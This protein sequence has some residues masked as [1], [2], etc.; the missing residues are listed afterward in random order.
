MFKLNDSF[1]RPLWI[2]VV[3][4][5]LLALWTFFEVV[6]GAIGWA[7]IWGALCVY[8]AYSFFINFNPEEDEKDK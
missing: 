6:T 2:R 7:M 8:S 4:V 1:Y 5:V 3:L